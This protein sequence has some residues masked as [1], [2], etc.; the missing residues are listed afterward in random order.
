MN[1]KIILFVLA[2]LAQILA[3]YEN[4]GIELDTKK[5]DAIRIYRNLTYN[6]RFLR[7]PC[8]LAEDKAPAPN[9]V[10]M[11]NDYIKCVKMPA[12]ELS[13][14]VI[15]HKSGYYEEI[16]PLYIT[17]IWELDGHSYLDVAIIANAHD[18]VF[19][20]RM[21]FCRALAERKLDI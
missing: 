14:L 20:N 21:E 13:S 1:N 7:I 10:D 17:E 18:F 6:T 9:C 3:Y 19:Y 11:L 15:E 8:I 4:L 5:I 12:F 2:T 16:P